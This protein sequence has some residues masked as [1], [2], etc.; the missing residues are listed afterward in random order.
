MA[1]QF[2]INEILRNAQERIVKKNGTPRQVLTE[3]QEKSFNV[4]LER[5]VM[6]F[7]KAIATRNFSDAKVISFDLQEVLRRLNK[8]SKLVEFKNQL[9]EL[10]SEEKEYVFAI[11]GLEANRA[12]VKNTTRLYLEATALLAITHLRNGNIEKAKPLIKEVLQ[13]QKVIKS[14]ATRAKFNKEI[15]VRF[16]EEITLFALKSESGININEGEIEK[17]VQ[18]ILTTHS[19]EQLYKLI[20]LETSSNIKHLL[21]EVDSYSKKLLPAKEQKLL[22]PPE[23]LMQDEPAGRTVFSSFKRVI[24]NSL[25]DP[26]SE[27]YKMW[28]TNGVAQLNKIIL[29]IGTISSALNYFGIAKTSIIVYISALVVRFGLDVYCDKYRPASIMEFRRKS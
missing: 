14:E 19:N 25:C 9:Y 6:Q 15:I 23:E 11:S 13:N 20:G 3:Q 29:A 28:F 1:E 7:K 8:Q 27:V 16:D 21:F 10:A 22:P 5:L 12:I 26:N 24:Y 2:N 4:R 18:S 17:Q